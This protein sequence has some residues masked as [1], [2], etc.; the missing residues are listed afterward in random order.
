MTYRDD[1]KSAV[2]GDHGVAAV[3][4]AQVYWLRAPLKA[5]APYIILQIVTEEQ[6]GTLA[7]NVRQA[8]IRL[9]VS[10]YGESY[11]DLQALDAAVHVALGDGNSPQ[12]PFTSLRLFHTELFEDDT[13]LFHLVTEFS[14]FHPN[15]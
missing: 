11:T 13:R 15:P 9:M 12:P 8:E 5:Q 6:S 14:I 2:L 3:V 7:G 1:I 4:G 10:M